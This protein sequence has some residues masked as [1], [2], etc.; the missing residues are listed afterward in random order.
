MEQAIDLFLDLAEEFEDCDNI[1]DGLRNLESEGELSEEQYNYI[2]QNWDNI[3][4][5][6]DLL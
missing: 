1:L 5:E 2:I 3:L 4:K 6:H